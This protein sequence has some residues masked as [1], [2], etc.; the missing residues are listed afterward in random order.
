MTWT[1]ERQDLRR[2]CAGKEH[3]WPGQPTAKGTPG[4]HDHTSTVQIMVQVL[5]D[6]TRRE[7]TAPEIGRSRRF[8]WSTARVNGLWVSWR[9]T[10]KSKCLLVLVIR[11]RRQK[12]TW[13]MLDSEE[14]N[15]VPLDRKESSEVH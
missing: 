9:G 5:C 6:G 13:A 4:A 2:E 7:S 14:R 12:M 1:T 3:P 8:G 10:L 15:G 11:E